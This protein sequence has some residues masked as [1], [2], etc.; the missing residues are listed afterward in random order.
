VN[1]LLFFLRRSCELL[2]EVNQ[3]D[4]FHNRQD[5]CVRA[6]SIGQKALR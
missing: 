6:R 2:L 4:E 1:A 5:G 3:Q